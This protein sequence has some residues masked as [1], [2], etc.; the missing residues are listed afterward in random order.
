[1]ISS[2][3]QPFAEP[4]R[5]VLVDGKNQHANEDLAPAPLDPEDDITSEVQPEEEGIQ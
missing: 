1:M 3:R 5:S 4:D 2:A